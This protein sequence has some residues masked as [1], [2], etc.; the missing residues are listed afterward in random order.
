MSE[1]SE[2]NCGTSVELSGFPKGA[3]NQMKMYFYSIITSLIFAST[4]GAH[5]PEIK[6]LKEIAN[7]IIRIEVSNDFVNMYSMLNAKTKTRISLEKF[8]L[9]LSHLPR[10]IDNSY[11]PASTQIYRDNP[12]LAYMIMKSDFNS[13]PLLLIMVLENNEWKLLSFP[14][15][16]AGSILNNSLQRFLR[17]ASDFQ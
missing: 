4:A 11:S 15:I 3:N 1:R 7:N 9:M 16:R 13:A 14:Q 10:T 12:T 17:E 8:V 6:S 5:E 2:L